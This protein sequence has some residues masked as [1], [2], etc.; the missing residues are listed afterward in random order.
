MHL[1]SQGRPRASRA[2]VRELSL[3]QRIFRLMSK[4]NKRL[5]PRFF[6]PAGISNVCQDPVTSTER[7]FVCLFG[8]PTVSAPSNANS[9]VISHSFVP[10]ITCSFYLGAREC[11]PSNA[12]LLSGIGIAMC[13][14]K[15]AS[16][17]K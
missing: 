4:L 15:R 2:V 11:V 10:Q 3:L 5:D 7:P 14:S 9:S 12:R 1:T 13:H 17:K 8:S 16:L 6:S